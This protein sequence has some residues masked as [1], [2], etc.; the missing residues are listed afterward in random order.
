MIFQ[1]VGCVCS[2]SFGQGFTDLNGVYY[3]SLE[4]TFKD[5]VASSVDFLANLYTPAG[6]TSDDFNADYAKYLDDM[7]LVC[8]PIANRNLSYYV[9]QSLLTAPPDPTVKAF[10]RRFAI[11]D[12]GIMEDPNTM[13][14]MVTQIGQIAT[15]TTGIVDCV[16]MGATT[17]NPIYKTASEYEA[18]KADQAKNKATISNP[19]IDLQAALQREADLRAR[20]AVAEASLIQ[21]LVK[22]DTPTP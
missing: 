20:L 13:L 16:T 4:M 2:L 14:P 7:V 3:I 1:S 15:A 11:I 22:K 5:A 6:K 19:V 9:P 17:D 18:Y 21:Y 10:N 8:N 12:L